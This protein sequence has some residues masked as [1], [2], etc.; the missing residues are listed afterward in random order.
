MSHA[1]DKPFDEWNG[2]KKQVER[3]RPTQQAKRREIWW[4][5]L[6]INIGHEQD[7]GGPRFER[8]ALILRVFGNDTCL[9]APLTN[10]P[11]G[12]R[13]HFDLECHGYRSRVVISQLRII[14]T[15]RLSRRIERIDYA[16][17]VKLVEEVR[18]AN[19]FL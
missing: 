11:G 8:P 9:I 19:G 6:G 12:S 5:D 7:G 15:Q 3:E 17:F 14:S 4:A 13:F 16:T 18:R 2:Q 10:A 1:H